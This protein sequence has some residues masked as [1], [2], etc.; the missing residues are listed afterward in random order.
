MFRI[1]CIAG[2]IG[3]LNSD[4]CANMI[5]FQEKFNAVSILWNHKLLQTPQT[6]SIPTNDLQ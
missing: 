5:R 4:S 2:V 3:S 1:D 6:E